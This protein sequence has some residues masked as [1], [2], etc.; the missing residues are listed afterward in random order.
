MLT[1]VVYL[2][3]NIRC[4]QSGIFVVLFFLCMNFLA[5][6][7]ELSATYCGLH[8]KLHIYG[9]KEN[10]SRVPDQNGYLKHDIYQ[11]YTILVG[12]PRFM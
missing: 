12:K 7:L 4:D 2:C 1:F 9:T 5:V 8:K 10:I 6:S 3:L 11:R